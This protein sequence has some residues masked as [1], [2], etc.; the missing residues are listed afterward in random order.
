MGLEIHCPPTT[1]FTP[2]QLSPAPL[3][4]RKTLYNPILPQS[5]PQI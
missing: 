2:I 4:P 3:I 1:I 5:L